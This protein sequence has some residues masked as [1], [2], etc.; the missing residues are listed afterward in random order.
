MRSTRWPGATRAG[1][2]ASATGSDSASAASA[3]ARPL[4]SMAADSSSVRPAGRKGP[5]ESTS[6]PLRNRTRRVS[7]S[8][9]LGQFDAALRARRPP[10]AGR[11]LDARGPPH[12]AAAQRRDAFRVQHVGDRLQR[13]PLLAHGGDA[14]LQLGHVGDRRCA[15]CPCRASAP[16]RGRAGCVRRSARAPS[17]RRRRPP[18]PRAGRPPWTCRS[19]GRSRSGSVLLLEPGQ[20]RRQVRDVRREVAQP[21]DDERVG[22]LL[23]E[24][25]ERPGQRRPVVAAERSRTSC[26]TVSSSRSRSIAAGPDRLAVAAQL[27]VGQFYDDVADRASSRSLRHRRGGDRRGPLAAEPVFGAPRPRSRARRRAPRS[28]AEPRAHTRRCR[29]WRAPPRSQPPEATRGDSRR[30]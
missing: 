20:Q 9:P 10:V 7:V 22:A 18:S 24:L 23:G 11:A 21:R 13:H 5:D 19:T 30:S 1:S 16:P 27:A 17:R 29:R 4:S 12:R 28:T 8:G 14:L 2:A 25:L 6:D 15:R 3:A 26:T